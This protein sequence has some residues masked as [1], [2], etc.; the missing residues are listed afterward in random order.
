MASSF[1][2]L[3]ALVQN[4]FYGETAYME[5][6]KTYRIV[7]KN[8]KK[9]GTVEIQAEIDSEELG[10][11]RAAALQ[12]LAENLKLPGFRKGHIPESVAV[13]YLPSEEILERTARK[14][15]AAAYPHIIGEL[16][17][18]PIS[19]PRIAIT[20]LAMG[21]PLAFTLS[22]A[23]APDVKLPNYKTI[24]KQ[25]MDKKEEQEVSEKEVDDIIQEF[26][27]I[28]QKRKSEEGKE[29]ETPRLTD[30]LAKE[31]GPFKTAEEVRTR[32]RE[33]LKRQKE[34][35]IKKQKR[36]ELAEALA[37]AVKM[38][39]PDIAIEEEMDQARNA[40]QEHLE[41]QNL[42]KEEF[43]KKM[44]KTEEKLWEEERRS[45]ERQFKT[46]LILEGIAE[47]EQITATP[48]EIERELQVFKKQNPDAN[49]EE[50]RT[51]LSL[52]IRNEKTIRF[53]E[54]KGGK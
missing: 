44:G 45:I 37:E 7:A 52:I 40:L 24:A 10:R 50:T 25:V 29:T 33:D 16:E 3:V 36:E 38:S 42:P 1:Y 19:S 8:R 32:I 6:K 14:T 5:N 2:Y 28:M 17:R 18:K 47:T 23:V 41:K 43:L 20:K 22:I 35:A 27:K 39:V 15:L 26:L 31:L 54:E 12:E 48:E 34:A 11:Y 46:R 21:N 49:E 9:D 51:Y 4:L 53:L 30:E 13:Q